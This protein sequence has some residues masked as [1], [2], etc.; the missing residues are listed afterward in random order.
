M[1]YF[2]LPEQ[3]THNPKRPRMIILQDICKKLK[4][5]FAHSRKGDERGTWFV[6][7]LVAIILPFTSSKT[8]N[9]LRCLKTLFGFTAIR[10][11]RYYTFMASPKIPWQRLWRCLW[12][13]IPE[14]LTNDRLLL[15]L[16]DY[17]NPKTG[18]KVFGCAKVFDHAAKQNQSKYP[19]AQNIVAI[20]LLKMVKGRWACLPLSYRFYHLKKS[21]E[22]RKLTQSKSEIKFETKL[23]QAVNMITDIAGTFS[24]TRIIAVT[25]SWFGNNGLWSPLNK[26]LGQWF[27]MISRLRSNNNVFDLPGS[28][29]KK[30]PGRPKK[31]GKKL[32]NTSSLA[33]QYKLLA[34][35]YDVNLYGRTRTIVAYDR[36]VMLKT[37]KCAVK[38]VWVYRKTQWVAL[39][40]TDLTLS[41]EKIIEYYGARWKIEAAFK[42]LKRDIGSAQTQTRHPIAVMNHLHFCMLATSL[43][44]IYASRLEKTPSRRHV[45][46]GRN[47]FAF[48]DVRRLIAQAALDDNFGILFPVPRKSAV[49]SLVSVLLRMAA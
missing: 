38:V 1:V 6:Y 5:E 9:L 7:T 12:K 15:A 28:R 37:L 44:W 49:N 22:K 21:I 35:E 8:S 24:Q 4:N 43:T 23:E 36:V 10:K 3:K 45:V 27:H 47:H 18:K 42:E 34:N 48:S 32:G 19:W 46:K 40:S 26:K 41:V 25:D 13:M 11:K 16:D 39:F 31:Y 17:I 29:T 30:G 14:T 20:G 33:L 2:I